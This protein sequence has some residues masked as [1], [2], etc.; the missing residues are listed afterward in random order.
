MG[1]KVINPE[2]IPAEITQED[3]LETLKENKYDKNDRF[4]SLWY[5]LISERLERFSSERQGLDYRMSD[6]E[7]ILYIA[8][9][10]QWN[11]ANHEINAIDYN[12][13]KKFMTE[14]NE[15]FNKLSNI[16]I[17]GLEDAVK[18]GVDVEGLVIRL[19]EGLIKIEGIGRVGATK[20]LHMRL[21]RLFV[22]IDNSIA[23]QRAY[24]VRMD[25][26]HFPEDYFRFLLTLSRMFRNVYEVWEKREDIRISYGREKTF[27]KAIDEYNYLKTRDA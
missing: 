8:F 14:N 17:E 4:R 3:F 12:G 1:K 21:P 26:E 20:I 2:L 19:V 16:G 15:T 10:S 25:D 11:R 9:I 27:A 7:A 23:H 22:P 18:S 5:Y 24:R 13:F 6:D